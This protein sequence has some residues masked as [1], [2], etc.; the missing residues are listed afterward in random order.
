MSTKGETENEPAIERNSQITPP[1]D[2]TNCRKKLERKT[3]AREKI[4]IV[5]GDGEMNQLVIVE[6]SRAVTTSLIVAEVFEKD[7]KNVLKD[8]RE[9]SCSED[10][11]RLNFEQSSYIN[12]QNKEMPLVYMNKKGFTLLAM[13]YTGKEAMKFKEAYI[14]QF[15]MMEQELN[16]PRVLSE[17][18]QLMASMKLSLETAGEIAAVKEEVEEIKVTLN[19]Q[20]TLDHGQ[21]VTLHHAIKQRVSAIKNDYEVSDQKLYSQIHSHLR[22]A[23]AAPKYIFVKRKDFQEAMSWIKSWR[24]L[25]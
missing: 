18:E 12:S 5:T 3:K 21:Q 19:N 14:D 8:I 25:L 20:L 7:H 2:S 11:R 6:N 13:G 16:K 9:L 17:R 10:F 23:F 24:P 22:R 15:E 4:L 1:I